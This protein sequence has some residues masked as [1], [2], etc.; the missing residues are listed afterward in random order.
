[1]I[2][3]Y[4]PIFDPCASELSN[5]L[6]NCPVFADN[7]RE[8]SLMQNKL[9]QPKLVLP[10]LLVAL[11]KILFMI[12]MN[13]VTVMMLHLMGWTGHLKLQIRNYG[14]YCK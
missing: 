12:L 2:E 8:V 10:H 14:G 11:R 7:T 5:F 4:I 6:H 13:M 1:M 3:N 9:F